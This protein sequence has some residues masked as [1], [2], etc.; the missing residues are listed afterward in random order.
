MAKAHNKMKQDSKRNTLVDAVETAVR[1]IFMTRLN[2]DLR[3]MWN[4]LQGKH[5]AVGLTSLRIHKV[6]EPIDIKGQ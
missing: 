1:I 3:W 5:P 4:T 2:G 6:E